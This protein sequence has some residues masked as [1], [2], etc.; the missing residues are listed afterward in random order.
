MNFKESAP[1]IALRQATVLT[2]FTGFKRNG[3]GSHA[4][5]SPA[6]ESAERAVGEA[7]G[8]SPE[9]GGRITLDL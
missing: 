5:S 3:C 4:R 7:D 8:L 6:R 9:D 1:G 2:W